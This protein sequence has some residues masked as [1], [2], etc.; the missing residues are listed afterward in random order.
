MAKGSA[1]LF[2]KGQDRKY[3]WHCGPYGL[4]HNYVSAVVAQSR[5][6]TNE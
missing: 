1:N 2:C 4:C 3:F 6:Y 5:Q